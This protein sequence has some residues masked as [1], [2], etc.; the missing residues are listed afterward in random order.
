MSS[1]SPSE[2][3][4]DDEDPIGDC[5]NEYPILTGSPLASLANSLIFSQESG[6]DQKGVVLRVLDELDEFG[7]R[8]KNDVAR[9]P[10]NYHFLREIQSNLQ[11]LPASFV[12]NRM[13]A[14]NLM[15]GAF[16]PVG[17]LTARHLGL[18]N[19]SSEE[20]KVEMSVCYMADAGTIKR[21]PSVDSEIQTVL[22][23]NHG[24][25][26]HA[27]GWASVQR[28]E[29]CW[30]GTCLMNTVCQCTPGIAKEWG[31]LFGDLLASKDKHKIEALTFFTCWYPINLRDQSEKE[32]NQTSYSNSNNHLQDMMDASNSLWMERKRWSFVKRPAGYKGWTGT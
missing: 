17:L 6:K 31:R 14:T 29:S 15:F 21:Q 2:E 1:S 12:H 27:P 4:D 18:N 20:D 13:R 3:D 24:G 19:L 23:T 11:L 16:W 32:L 26:C 10:E 5:L 30:N 25:G 22:H 28:E 7:L 8:Y 9:N